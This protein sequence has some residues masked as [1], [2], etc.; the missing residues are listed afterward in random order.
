MSTP[1]EWIR[2]AMNLRRLRRRFPAAILHRGVAISA[3]SSL[4]VSVVLFRGASV[5]QSTVGAYSYLQEDSLLLYA[6]VGPFCSI[7]RR[8]SVGLAA[9]EMSMVSTS[10]VF[11]DPGQ[12][13]PTFFTT[14]HHGTAVQPKTLIGPDVWIGEGAMLKAGITVGVGA[15]IGAGA[16]VT[17]DVEPYA[18]T[19]G[20]PSRVIRA[21]FSP[22]VVSALVAS[23]WW[24]LDA[25]TLHRVAGSFVDPLVFLASTGQSPARDK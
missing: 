20:N 10:P 9:H 2:Q 5:L 7:A 19:A 12:P 14:A 25:S 18:I 1:I 15:V 13:L 16:V 21:R 22:A 24:K 23:E 11:Y 4:G 17:R 3:D 6:D 8:V